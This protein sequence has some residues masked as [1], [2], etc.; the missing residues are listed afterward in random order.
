MAQ[1]KPIRVGIMGFGRTG[2]QIYE[3][4]SRSSDV[5]VVAVA[6]IGK[7]EILHY[8]L[9]SEV[10]EPERHQLRGN[11]L[12]TGFARACCRLTGL[13]KCPG[14]FGVDMVIVH[15]QVPETN[16]MQGI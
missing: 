11:F 8:L 16:Y 12:V 2:R 3:L 7:P 13:R 14:C 6:D 15:W 4:A 5:E 1:G 10:Q 9:G